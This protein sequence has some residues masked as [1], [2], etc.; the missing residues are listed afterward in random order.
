LKTAYVAVCAITI[1]FAVSV[2][3]PRAFA[4][5][6]QPTKRFSRETFAKPEGKADTIDSA[7][8]ASQWYL[9]GATGLDLTTTVIGMGEHRGVE[10]GWA[11]CFGRNNTAGVLAANGA[12]D[13]GVSFASRRIYRM[14]GRWRYLA[15]AMN[16][17][18]ATGIAS[19]GIHNVAY[20]RKH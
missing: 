16:V 6:F 14:G 8:T 4:Q 9:R 10:A 1:V 20:L 18:R 2:N 11:K 12:V 5:N 19:D 17:A 13:F 3:S 15:I 7:Y